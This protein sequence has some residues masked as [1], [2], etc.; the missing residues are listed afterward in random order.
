MHLRSDSFKP[1]DFL[2][3]D[4]AF[5]RY[6]AASHVTLAG[7]RNPHLA[8]SEVPAGTRSFAL[9]CFDPDV[10]SRGDDVNREDRTVPLDLPR[11]DFFH[12]VVA[13]LP[14]ELR[15]IAAGSHSAGV[16]P[17][18]KA[19]A[20]TPDGGLTGLNDYTGWFSED[21]DMRGAYAGYDGPGPPWNDE[22]VHGYRFCLYALDVPSVGLA[23]AFDGH[24]LRKAIA[25]HVL[26]SAELVALY[27]INPDA[28]QR[29]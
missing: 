28:P 15:A 1:Y 6:D 12:W 8:W 11:V 17:R 25:G 13:D 4:F 27:A 23:G 20:A 19:P 9:I 22:R 21:P 3:P 14:A 5:G 29:R 16:T 18:G 26:A 24:A 10:P 7:N 2:H